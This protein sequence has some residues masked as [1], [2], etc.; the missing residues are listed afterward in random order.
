MANK[1]TMGEL[2]VKRMEIPFFEGVNTVVGSNIAKKNEFEHVDNARSVHIGTIE[3]RAGTRR[4][5]DAPAFTANYALF[6]FENEGETNTGFYRISTLDGTTEVHY[7]NT[8]AAWTKI[9]ATASS[10][11]YEI[12]DSTTQF[13]ITNTAGDT[14]RYSWDGTGTDPDVDSRI[15][16]GSEVVTAAQNFSAGNNGTFT[17]TAAGANYFEVTNASGVAESNVTIGTGS[18]TVTGNDFDHVVAEECCFL[19][20]GHHD[21]FYITDDAGTGVVSSVTSTGHLYGSP[22]ARKI[23]HYKDRLYIGDYVTE[24]GIRYKNGIMMS[25]VPLGI[26]GLID[27]DHDTGSTE[28]AV[29]D[30]KYIQQTDSLQVFRGAELVENLTITGKTED[31]ITVS[32]TVVDLYSADEIWVTNTNTDVG[33]KFRWAQPNAGGV[34]VREYDAFKLTGGE[35]DRIKLLTP[36]NDILMMGNNN[37]LAT[38][39]NY[40]FRTMDLGIG[41]VSDNGYVK[42]LGTLFFV[43]YTGIYA[44]N[45]DRPRLVSAKVQ[46]YIDGATRAG[47]ENASAGREGLSTFFHIGEVT[48]YR[49]DGSIRETL[50]DVVLEYNMRQENWFVQTEINAEMFRTYPK[51]DDADRLQFA[52]G[53]DGDFHVYEFLNGDVDDRVTS[54]KEIT[55]RVDTSNITLCRAFENWAYLT[56]VVVEVERGSAVKCFL[57]LDGG[58]WYELRGEAVKGCTVLKASARKDGDEQP[59]RCRRVRLSLRD[60]SRKRCRISR[61]ALRYAESAEELPQSHESYV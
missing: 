56:D 12:G 50:E 11:L 51:T 55:M 26:V 25:S 42:A 39:D 17:V 40:T 38:W 29:T 21:N 9:T 28:L 4:L 61:V 19:V 59:L 32:A 18:I 33:R 31:S 15:R 27:G 57:S 49:P 14:Y 41:C 54:D 44:T 53:S 52:S 30:T 3:K 16:I 36:I 8:S 37:N 58:P 6:W 20:N 2:P 45:G 46:E 43:H 47:L 13:D 48:L 35:N 5:G 22:K 1:T 23:T 34:A 7:L 60:S 24:E 10:K